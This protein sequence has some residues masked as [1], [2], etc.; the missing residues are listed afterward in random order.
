MSLSCSLMQM[1]T[2]LQC[3]VFNYLTIR[4]LSI[5]SSVSNR[6]AVL[7]IQLAAWDGVC[8]RAGLQERA[9]AI[10]PRKVK[11]IYNRVFTKLLGKTKEE[12]SVVVLSKY[13]GVWHKSLPLRLSVPIHPNLR[14]L[15][16]NYIV[17]YKCHRLWYRATNEKF[18][19]SRA[20]H[21]ACILAGPPFEID[22]YLHELN[23]IICI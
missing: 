15:R 4:D 21:F 3:R 20:K 22:R 2:V 5:F 23:V 17:A 19:L 12:S 11:K 18:Y 6:M 7:L 8:N 10:A 14:R 1:P 13:C 16:R 9:G